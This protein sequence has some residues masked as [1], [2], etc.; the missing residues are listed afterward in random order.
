MSASALNCSK[1][2][3]HCASEPRPKKRFNDMHRHTATNGT[4]R[5]TSTV[6]RPNAHAQRVLITIDTEQNGAAVEVR[7]CEHDNRGEMRDAVGVPASACERQSCAVRERCQSSARG[8]RTQEHRQFRPQGGA[9]LKSTAA[10]LSAPRAQALPVAL[11]L[12]CPHLAEIPG[13]LNNTIRTL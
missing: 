5:T 6:S 10:A 12:Q 9:T 7:A 1:T 8:R 2:R 3:Y 13:F 11:W 4:Q